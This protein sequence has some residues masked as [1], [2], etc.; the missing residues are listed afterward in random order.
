[1]C[2]HP[3]RQSINRIII[4]GHFGFILSFFVFFLFLKLCVPMSG[5]FLSFL[6]L[7]LLLLLFRCFLFVLLL[8]GAFSFGVLLLHLTVDT[9]TLE[10]SGKRTVADTFVSC[11]THTIADH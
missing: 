6:L 2:V 3:S 11:H 4:Y 10:S 1:M 5:T 9:T 7:L 8:K